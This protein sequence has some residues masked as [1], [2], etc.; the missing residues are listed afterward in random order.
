MSFGGCV[1]LLAGICLGMELLDH[2]LYMHLGFVETA[3]QFG[4]ARSVGSPAS[5]LLH[6]LVAPTV[7]P[8][9]GHA[10]GA[11]WCPFRGTKTAKLTSVIAPFF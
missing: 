9:V 11:Q 1:Y 4:A 5:P 7:L 8:H 6:Q 3:K 2:G 10:S